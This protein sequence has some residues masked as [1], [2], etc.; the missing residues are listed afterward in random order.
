MCRSRYSR[1]HGG[2]FENRY[3]RRAFQRERTRISALRRLSLRQACF[4][5]L[6]LLALFVQLLVVQTHIHVPPGARHIVSSPISSAAIASA[7]H[8]DSASGTQAP[9]DPYP[10]SD[11]PSNCPLCQEMAH[12]GQFISS[13]AALLVLPVTVSV[14]F[15]VFREALPSL[16][17]ASHSWRGRAPPTA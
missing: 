4:V 15:I 9:R 1:A 13:A 8:A 2:M 12:S 7:T 11:D 17:E 5:P 14:A 10:A 16:V 6:A 3:C